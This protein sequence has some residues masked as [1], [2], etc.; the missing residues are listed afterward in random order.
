MASANPGSDYR[1]QARRLLAELNA[2]AS[3]GNLTNGERQQMMAEIN[4][5]YALADEQANQRRAG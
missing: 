2:R 4:R 3:E 1:S 5:L